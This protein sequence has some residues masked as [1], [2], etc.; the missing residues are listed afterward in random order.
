MFLNLIWS[1]ARTSNCP[2]STN[3][4]HSPVISS[5]RMSY[6]GS[7]IEDHTSGDE[8][9]HYSNPS[10]T[11]VLLNDDDSVKQ[12]DILKSDSSLG[13]NNTTASFSMCSFTD[14]T[15]AAN[16]SKTN[17]QMTR[18]SIFQLPWR[19]RGDIR[20]EYANM[21]VNMHNYNDHRLLREFF[22]TF[23][24][25]E[26]H[27]ISHYAQAV[28]VNAPKTR[29]AKSRDEMIANILYDTCFFADMVF[30]LMSRKLQLRKGTRGQKHSQNVS[31]ITLTVK[32]EATAVQRVAPKHNSSIHDKEEETAVI[33]SCPPIPIQST[34]HV[35]FFLD[36]LFRIYCVQCI[37]D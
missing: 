37:A 21:W 10:S 11:I 4:Y 20:D 22:E 2:A 12:E 16:E 26:C 19:V 18:S 33:V 34:M 14:Q 17:K 6:Y 23:A 5:K 1:P 3:N 32:V 29:C 7:P 35:T 24:V 25:P 36:E 28:K 31:S 15:N 8:S 13:I 30:R 27:L 9:T